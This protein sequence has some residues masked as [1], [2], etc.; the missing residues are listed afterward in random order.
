MSSTGTSQQKCGCAGTPGKAA[1]A[2]PELVPGHVVQ[3]AQDLEDICTG[4]EVHNR[5][6][7]GV[8]TDAT[9]F[10]VVIASTRRSCKD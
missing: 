8:L 6:R 5:T 4:P 10:R 3:A 1:V 2:Q 7:P 9:P